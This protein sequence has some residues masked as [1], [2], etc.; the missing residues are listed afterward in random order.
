MGQPLPGLSTSMEPA[1]E[2]CARQA[3]TRRALSNIGLQCQ[4]S[5]RAAA[6]GNAKFWAAHSGQHAKRERERD[7][8]DQI[9]IG[10]NW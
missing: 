5:G 7:K 3:G 10:A 6:H 8:I 9:V 2:A 4:E 1:R